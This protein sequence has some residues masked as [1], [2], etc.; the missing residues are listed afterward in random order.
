MPVYRLNLFGFLASN[1]LLEDSTEEEGTVGDLGFWDQR[2]AIEWTF[3]NIRDFGGNENNIT[4]GGLSAGA[5][6]VFHQLS[7][8]LGLPE[9]QSIIRR[10]VMYSNGPGV[11]PKSLLE[12]QEQFD[13]LLALLGNHNELTGKEKLTRLKAVPWTEL[14]A[15]SGKMT[16]N[17]FRAVTDGGFIR[18]TLFQEIQDGRFATAMAQRE[19]KIL[20]GDLPD[21]LS[22]YRLENP[23]SSYAGLVERLHVEYPLAATKALMKIYCPAKALP[24]GQS[25]QDLF[26]R[27]YADVQVH[28]TERGFIAALTPTLPLSHIYRY[29]INWRP[30]CVDLIY[31]K[32]WGIAHGSDLAIWFYGSGANLTPGERILIQQFLKP[33]AAYLKGEEPSWGTQSI[34]QAKAILQDGSLGFVEDGDWDTCLRVWNRLQNP[35]SSR[36]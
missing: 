20:I 19:M 32:D 23:P 4:L 12:A 27:I 14:I 29:R 8:E 3:K 35:N 18:R 10:V 15:A 16:K 34:R 7:Y 36:L 28:V 6:S 24:S 11:Q 30:K 5:H 13:E 9:D 26:G 2:L 1:E 21:E 22:I 31:P 25:W 17:S 33:F